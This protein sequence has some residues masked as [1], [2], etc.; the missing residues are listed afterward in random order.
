MDS[1]VVSGLAAMGPPERVE[2]TSGQSDQAGCVVYY[3]VYV[4]VPA[5]QVCKPRFTRECSPAR[6][7]ARATGP[8]GFLGDDGRRCWCAAVNA[9]GQSGRSPPAHAGSH[10]AWRSGTSRRVLLNSIQNTYSLIERAQ[11]ERNRPSMAKPR[12]WRAHGTSQSLCARHVEQPG[13]SSVSTACRASWFIGDYHSSACLTA[14]G[15]RSITRRKFLA[16]LSG[17]R[18]PSSQSRT[19]PSGR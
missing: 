5:S 18:R 6:L 15:S 2:W 4:R 11:D 14:S 16:A 9:A 10:G 3:T 19:V 17:S 13:A 1:A 8:S 12:S 7:L